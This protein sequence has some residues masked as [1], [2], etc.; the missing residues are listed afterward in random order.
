[1]DNA[2][3]SREKCG[4]IVVC[5]MIGYMATCAAEGAWKNPANPAAYPTHESSI[6]NVQLYSWLG[7]ARK[8]TNE[9]SYSIRAVPNRA[10]VKTGI[11]IDCPAKF[12]NLLVGVFILGH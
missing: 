7:C 9:D 5:Q 12:P 8:P 3:L 11:L 10:P 1:M 2:P 6:T 4:D